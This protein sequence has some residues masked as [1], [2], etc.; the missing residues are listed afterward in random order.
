[1]PPNDELTANFGDWKREA[2]N[3]I[4]CPAFICSDIKKWN[5]KTKSTAPPPFQRS[6]YDPHPCIEGPLLTRVAVF[7]CHALLFLYGLIA[8]RLR[9]ARTS[10]QEERPE[11][12]DFAPLHDHFDSLFTN[13]IYRMASDVLNRPIKGVPGA[14]VVIKERYSN[15]FGWTYK[16]TG[17]ERRVINL[18]S[19]NY[20]GFSHKE[21]PC[22][23]AAACAI[24]QQG[25]GTCATGD[26]AGKRLSCSSNR[27]CGAQRELEL[28]IARYLRTEDA[29]CFPMGFGVNT[30]VIPALADENTLALSDALNHSSIVLGLRLAKATIKVFPHNDMDKL[31]TMLRNALVARAR[32]GRPP[33]RKVLVIAE[34]IFSMEGTIVN[35]P[36]LVE[37]KR[38]YGCFLYLD[39]AHSI[40]SL[41]P[42][43]R[44]V[45][46][47]WGIDAR[48]VDVLMGTI[49][50]SFAGAGGYIAGTRAL[51]QHLRSRTPGPIYSPTMSPPV[52]AQVITSLKISMTEVGRERSALLLRNTR[53]FRRRLKAMGFIVYGSADSAVIPVL[54]FGMP[55]TVL[56]GR[57]ALK[58]GVAVV[59]VGAPATP[60]NKAR[61]RFCVS[62]SHTREQLDEALR[63]A[64]ACGELAGIK[65]LDAREESI[66]Y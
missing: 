57:E 56:F 38:R 41:G 14:E 24:D 65:F 37:I 64:D 10:A 23:E 13:N 43:G 6:P 63:V 40:G 15:D 45:T 32:S 21:G 51:V 22:A 47:Y 27:M 66:I 50:K 44:G 19:Y 42:T 9:I 20:L 26:E 34:G 49:T 61:A 36:R 17:V 16:F 48:E 29:I 30:Q 3:G 8:E 54:S 46:E 12:R 31:E 2:A 35:L 60:L 59:S 7:L 33:F 4:D 5:A 28:Q 1:M 18:G 52:I 11:Q 62:A 55:R 39:E 53:Y 25:L 58:R